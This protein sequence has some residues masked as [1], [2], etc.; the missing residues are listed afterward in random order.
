MTSDFIYAGNPDRKWEWSFIPNTPQA[1]VEA[2]KQGYNAFT[3]YSFEFEPT[4]ENRKRYSRAP[5]RKG[6]LWIDLDCKENP[7]ASI[8][9]ARNFIAFLHGVFNGFNP[10]MVKYFLSGSK[11][12]HICIP[13]EMFDGTDGDEEL[14]ILHR[15]LMRNI[16]FMKEKCKPPLG[17][18]KW[19]LYDSQLYAMG[20]G[21]LLREKNLLRPDGRYKVQIPTRRFLEEDIEPL[22]SLTESHQDY[23]VDTTP[24]VVCD[25]S[26]LYRR[27]RII[28]KLCNPKNCKEKSLANCQ[29]VTHCAF[30]QDEVSEPQWFLMLR[31]LKGCKATEEDVR[32]MS[33]DHHAFDERETTKKFEHVEQ[34]PMPTCDE[35]SKVFDCAGNCFAKGWQDA[36]KRIRTGESG[37]FTSEED[38]LYTG[39][40]CWL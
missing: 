17:T 25:L 26:K 35:V 6:D 21:H 8:M 27:T 40:E 39:R 23:E 37:K 20:R 14:P 31:I 30:Y 1:R 3:P 32:E 18:N 7:A 5:L 28:R 10:N 2:I 16:L 4:D 9:E 12:C 24:P 33:R 19:G 38:G 15:E 22:L 11:G 36:F 13:A 34:Y 29:F